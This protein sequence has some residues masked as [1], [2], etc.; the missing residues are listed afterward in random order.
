VEDHGSIGWFYFYEKLLLRMALMTSEDAA[1][2]TRVVKV[3]WGRSEKLSS[4]SLSTLTP[5][6]MLR[7]QKDGPRARFHANSLLATASK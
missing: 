7:I 3:V 5:I 2:M 1:E 4:L 6:G